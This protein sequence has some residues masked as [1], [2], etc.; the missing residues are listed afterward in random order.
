[1]EITFVS[2]DVYFQSYEKE[3][4]GGYKLGEIQ[5]VTS[6]NMIDFYVVDQTFI[7]TGANG[8]VEIR[9][10]RDNAVFR[11]FPNTFLRIEMI[12]QNNI[13]AYMDSGEGYFFA[14]EFTGSREGDRIMILGPIIS[15]GVRGTGNSAVYLNVRDRYMVTLNGKASCFNTPNYARWQE[16]ELEAGKKVVMETD[17]M[18]ENATPEPINAQTVLDMINTATDWENLTLTNQD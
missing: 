15:S 5:K 18:P 1:M 9:G 11:L 12:R 16:I 14:K 4:N 7:T 10:Y 13:R 3:E 2:G 17:L 8:Y 6:D